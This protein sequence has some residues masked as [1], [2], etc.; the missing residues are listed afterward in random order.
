MCAMTSPPHS[1]ALNAR[2]AVG[3]VR[4]STDRQ[5]QSLRGQRAAIQSYADK[6]G[7]DIRE[8]YE[9]DAISLSRSIFDPGK[10]EKLNIIAAASVGGHYRLS[11]YNSAGEVVRHLMNTVVSGTTVFKLD[12][13]GKNAHGDLVASGVYLIHVETPRFADTRRIAVLRK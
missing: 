10:G 13:D 3:Y 11:V 8:W 9:D 6:N 12:W 5:E 4:R 2:P 7:F 1:P